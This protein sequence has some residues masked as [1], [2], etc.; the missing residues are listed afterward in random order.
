MGLRI[1]G[2]VKTCKDVRRLLQAGIPAEEHDAFREQLMVLL[3]QVDSMCAEHGLTPEELPTPSRNAY[4]FLRQVDLNDLPVCASGDARQSTKTIQM[5]NVVKIGTQF[6]QLL[7]ER[8]DRL[9]GAPERQKTIIKQMQ[10]HCGTIERCCEQQEATP[11]ALELP[12]KQVYA[13]MKFLTQPEQL[14]AQ[15][16]VLFRMRALAEPLLEDHTETLEIQLIHM[17]ALWRMKP[18]KGVFVL[19]CSEGFVHAPDDVLEAMLATIFSRKTRHRQ[20]VVGAFIDS[21]AYTSVMFALG[22]FVEPDV[23]HVKGV[24]HDLE[25]SFQRVNEAYFSSDLER[26]RIHWSQTPTTSKFGHYELTTDT[27]MISSVLDREKVPAFVLD[28]VMYHELLHKVHGAP[29]VGGRRMAH[30]PA[31]RRDE[32]KFAQYHEAEAF[33]DAWHE[34]FPM[35]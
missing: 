7:W 26:P 4:R 3:Q 19:K 1:K 23:E 11:A 30:T 29:L 20:K 24:V 22:S 16:D 5:Q 15:I 25:D 32:K 2:L 34:H 33:L 35:S 21:E 13:W 6:A 27:V 8:L 31:F 10:R 14:E 17:S 18:R 12:S 9:H 28:F